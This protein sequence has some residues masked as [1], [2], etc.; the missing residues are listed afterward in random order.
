MLVI[1]QS[2]IKFPIRM[3]PTT[4]TMT[5]GMGDNCNGEAIEGTISAPDGTNPSLDT[6]NKMG[7]T[8]STGVAAELVY[9]NLDTVPNLPKFL[10]TQLAINSQFVNFNKE[11]IEKDMY[12]SEGKLPFY[13]PI[14]SKEDADKYNDAAI[15]RVGFP[16]DPLPLPTAQ[17][18]SALLEE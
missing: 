5:N 2:R 7:A 10:T 14:V 13:D 8:A 4:P 18:D 6:I 11:K 17:F 1:G 16:D 15:T 3:E 12:N 9:N